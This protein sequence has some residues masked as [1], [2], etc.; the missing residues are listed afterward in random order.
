MQIGVIVPKPAS[1][2]KGGAERLY[3]GLVDGLNALGAVAKLV[4]VPTDEATYET[5]EE[6]YLRCYDLDVSGFDAVISTKAPTYAVRHERHICYLLHTMRTFYDMFDSVFPQ[7]SAEMELRRK[8]VIDLDT[9]ALRSPR[10]RRVF[11]IGHEVAARLARYNAITAEVLHP[12]STLACQPGVQGDY[13]L[14]PGRLHRWKR[15]DLAIDAVRRARCN[16]TLKICGVGEDEQ[17][18]REVA[19]TDRKIEFCGY[20]TDAELIKLYSNCLAVVFVPVREDFGYVALE[21]ISSAKPLITCTDS[22]EPARL[23]EDGHTGFIAEPN[24]SS[25]SDTI[26]KVAG[27]P[28]LA[29]RVGLQAKQQ[30]PHL[31]WSRIARLLLTGLDA[32]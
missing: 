18:F 27:D 3:Q 19:G 21:A 4:E 17:I 5:I 31:S 15:V 16:V 2:E 30:A 8:K 25:L 26:D 10:T 14:L 1:G 12:P 7:P 29:I 32:A 11:A 22:G 13:L 20:V 23:I 24:S 6:S 9:A 28:A